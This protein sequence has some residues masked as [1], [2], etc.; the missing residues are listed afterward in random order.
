MSLE[1][2]FALNEQCRKHNVKFISAE[3]RGAYSRILND[4]G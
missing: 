3:F 2:Q 1:K 4:F